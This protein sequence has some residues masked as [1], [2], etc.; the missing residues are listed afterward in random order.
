V[1]AP[2]VKA[3]NLVNYAPVVEKISKTNDMT[4]LDRYRTRLRGDL[5]LFCFE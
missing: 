4:L 5:D 3:I 2:V 1:I